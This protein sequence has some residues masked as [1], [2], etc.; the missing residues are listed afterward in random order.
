[1]S[2]YSE[3]YSAGGYANRIAG[4]LQKPFSLEQLEQVLRSV[5]PEDRRATA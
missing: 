4:F 2:G 5:L 1:M 3:R